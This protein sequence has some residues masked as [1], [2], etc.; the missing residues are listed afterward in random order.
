MSKFILSIK[1]VNLDGTHSEE[2]ILKSDI[3]H[4][5]EA[6]AWMNWLGEAY[7]LTSKHPIE[8]TVKKSKLQFD[9]FMDCFRQ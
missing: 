4:I 8:R 7:V 6:K 1:I 2:H 3:E 5:K 9:W